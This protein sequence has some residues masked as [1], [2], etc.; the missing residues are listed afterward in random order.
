MSRICNYLLWLALLLPALSLQA[1]ELRHNAQYPDDPAFAPVPDSLKGLILKGEFN[2]SKIYPET[3]R[4]WQ[5][6]V[7]VQYDGVTPACLL[8]GLDGILFNATTVLDNLIATGQM[9]VTIGVFVQPGVSYDAEGN[10][11]S[12]T[13][14]T[15]R[16]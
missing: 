3:R 12:T 4:E 10:V 8:V 9:P 16:K 14:P 13:Q 5:V 2:D 15:V 7:P 1:Q 11:V 6:Y